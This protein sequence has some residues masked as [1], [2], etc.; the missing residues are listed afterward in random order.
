MTALLSYSGLCAR[1]PHES[2]REHKRLLDWSN[3]KAFNSIDSRRMGFLDYTA[4]MNFCR[5]NG[6]MASESEVIAIVRRFDVDADQKITFEEFSAAM[7]MAEP[8]LPPRREEALS[9]ER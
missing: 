6:Y 2:Q 1:E 5:M 7:G 9:P 8:V 4:V 3:L